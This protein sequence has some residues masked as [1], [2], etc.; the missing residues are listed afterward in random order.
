MSDTD[1]GLKGRTVL[2]TGAGGGLG[3]Q[4]ALLFGK[5]GANVVVNDLGGSADGSGK[6]SAMADAVVEEIKAAGGNAVANY[7]SV[8]SPEGAEAMVKQAIDAFGSI[9]IVINNAGILRDKSFVK[10][11]DQD[12][13]LVQAVHVK[14]AYYV[15][16]AAW[17]HM[18]ENK[19]GR[20]I[21]T[22]SGSGIYG[23]F[24]QANY[25]CAK[26]GLVGF[27]QTLALEGEKYNIKTNVIA[28]VA[29]SRMTE[30]L[31]PEQVHDMIKPYFVSPLVVFLCSEQCDANGEVY[32]VGAGAFCRVETLRA[33]GLAV[34]PGEGEISLEAVAENWDKINDMSDAEVCRSLADSTGMTLKHCM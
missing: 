21:M 33:K 15:T 13:D 30:S 29:I 16:K 12:W 5:Y 9:D 19:W 2:V 24:G 20:V 11:T 28:P 27:G 26:M 18:R 7:D 4:H 8:S 25:S 34:K 22:A 1:F 14:G 32:E 23:N 17:P 31:M 6:G 10:M 3:R